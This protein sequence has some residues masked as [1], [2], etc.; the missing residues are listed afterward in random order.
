MLAALHE[1]MQA[2]GL[3]SMTSFGRDP[4]TGTAGYAVALRAATPILD[5]RPLDL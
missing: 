1:N 4:D 5:D 3:I 2:E